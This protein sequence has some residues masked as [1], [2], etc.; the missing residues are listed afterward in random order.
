MDIVKVINAIVGIVI[1][2]VGCLFLNITV[3]NEEFKT[4]TYKVFGF[5]T[6]CVGFFYLK[7]VAKF[8]KQ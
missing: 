5:I 4:I 6:L 2:L 1:I 7:K 8:G 3:V